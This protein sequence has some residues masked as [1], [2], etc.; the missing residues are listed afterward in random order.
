MSQSSQVFTSERSSGSPEMRHSS[1]RR[2]YRRLRSSAPQLRQS[3]ATSSARQIS[4]MRTSA[5]RPSRSTRTAIDTLS[6][7]SRFTADR[8]GI[9][10]SL[11]SSTTSL[12]R[13]RIVVV[14]GAMSALRNRGIAA[15][16]ERTTTGRRPTSGTSHH[17]T[18]PRAGKSV[19]SLRSP[20]GSC[21]DLPTHLARSAGAR[22]T[23]SSSHR[24]RPTGA[25]PAAPAMPGR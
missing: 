17:H 25:R 11:G 21:P 1:N 15:F 10:S 18:S 8:V 13:P 16:R 7:E 19:T 4:A 3:T 24:S 2:L 6:S 5:S 20:S 12:A 23:P 22:R 9:G 14:H